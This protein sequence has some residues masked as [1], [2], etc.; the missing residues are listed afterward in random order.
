MQSG[1]D[2]KLMV[3]RFALWLCLVAIAAGSAFAAAGDEFYSRLYSRGVTQFNE[4]NYAGAT[5]SLRLAAFGLLED[6]SRFETA[7]VYLSVAAMRLHHDNDAR[8]SA[9]RVVAAERIE[10]RYA[11]LALPETVRGEFENAART[12]LTPEQ[13]AQLHGGAS[14][15]APRPQVAQP[16]PAPP[17]APTPA[18]APAPAPKTTTI[19]VPAPVIVPAPQPQ[20]PRAN[21]ETLFADA[22]RA[23][24]N[25]D[26]TAARPLYKTIVDVPQLTHAEALRAAEGSYRSRDFATAIRAFQKAGAI[27]KGEEQY[28]YYYAVALYETGHYAEA[29]SE[30]RAGLPFIE[31]TP[32]VARYRSKIEGAIE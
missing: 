15:T 18:P 16:Q 14:A 7:Q 20:A 21:V 24:G 29:K 3:R 9:Q 6:V 8:Q 13:L 1:K 23:L 22:E 27:G 5:A 17:P 4:G 31:I 32:D 19:V 11:S 30:L 12:L 26:L 10:R 28:H 25:G 2:L